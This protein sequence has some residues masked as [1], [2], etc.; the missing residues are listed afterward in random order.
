[1]ARKNCTV[2]KIIVKLREKNSLNG[3]S[4]PKGMTSSDLAACSG[5]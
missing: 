5:P 3:R 4:H 2:E 1:M